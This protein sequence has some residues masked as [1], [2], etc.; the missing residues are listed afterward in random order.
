M[1]INDL[2]TRDGCRRGPPEGA[3]RHFQPAKGDTQLMQAFRDL[4]EKPLG[5]VA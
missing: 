3:Q 1:H 4:C 5:L 2:G